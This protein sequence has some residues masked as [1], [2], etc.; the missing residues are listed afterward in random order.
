[1]DRA[2]TLD[3]E[4]RPMECLVLYLAPAY[5]HITVSGAAPPLPAA[6]ARTH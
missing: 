4:L 5:H 3:A 1:M 2:K 6:M